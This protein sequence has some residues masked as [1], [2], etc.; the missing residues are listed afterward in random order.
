LG[1]RH[2][3]GKSESGSAGVG[4]SHCPQTAII[5]RSGRDT[6]DFLLRDTGHAY[7][8]DRLALQGARRGGPTA[9]WGVFR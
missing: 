3:A 6:F 8:S 5:D 1:F 4:H 9:T 2:L 7:K